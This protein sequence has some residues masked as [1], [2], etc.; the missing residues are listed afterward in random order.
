[1]NFLIRNTLP[2]VPEVSR[3]AESL[4]DNSLPLVQ[5][6]TS[7][8][9]GLIAKDKVPNGYT[10][11]DAATD[12]DKVGDAG[13]AAPDATYR[14]QGYHTDVSKNDGWITIPNSMFSFNINSANNFSGVI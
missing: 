12:S 7:T 8:L 14:N 10:G 2:I 5:Q 13:S 11:N 4:N 9:E 6:L 1:M 3:V